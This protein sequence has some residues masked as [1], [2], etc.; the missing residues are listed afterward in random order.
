MGLVLSWIETGQKQI[1]HLT[2]LVVVVS[3]N[4]PILNKFTW[5]IWREVQSPFKAWGKGGRYTKRWRVGG[6]ERMRWG[7]NG[8]R[9]EVRLRKRL[10]DKTANYHA[11]KLTSMSNQ[12]PICLAL[13]WDRLLAFV[14]KAHGTF[15]CPLASFSF[16]MARLAGSRGVLPRA[17]TP[18][19]SKRMPNSGWK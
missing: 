12:F 5:F 1:C 14:T 11:I 10:A 4:H 8:G 7:E 2:F 17:K 6:R 15:R 9:G 3:N 16:C 19:T 13:S 18:S